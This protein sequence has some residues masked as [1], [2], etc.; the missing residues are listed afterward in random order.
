MKRPDG[1]LVTYI[2]KRHF[3]VEIFEQQLRPLAPGDEIVF[4]ASWKERGITTGDRATI[5]AIDPRGNV[6]LRMEE[7][8]RA[9]MFSLSELRHFDYVYASTSYSAQGATSDRV[10]VHMNT[11]EKG[12]KA[13]L[14]SAMA[15][16]SLS[17]PR[18]EIKLYTDDVKR[19]ERMLEN[20]EV[21]KVAL[22]AEQI[23]AYGMGQGV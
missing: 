18:S 14:N 11:A 5:E 23:E 12:A 10:L 13:M 1:K 19:L 6:K 20:S 3:G 4:R 8:S 15:Y 21:K 16:V 9:V 2:P 17:R 22:R 7:R